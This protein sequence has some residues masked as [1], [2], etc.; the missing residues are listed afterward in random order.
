MI[1]AKTFVVLVEPLQDTSEKPFF[2][3]AAGTSKKTTGLVTQPSEVDTTG[4]SPV[5]ATGDV[6]ATLTATQVVEAPS[7]KMRV[8]TEPV[9]ANG[10]KVATQP[11]EA[12]G[13]RP[14]VQAQSTGTSS[15]KVRPVDQS[16]VSKKTSCYL[17]PIKMLLNSSRMFSNS[18]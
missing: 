6:V 10:V 1:L 12:P 14:V 4:P 18:S 2:Y 3:P 8:A 7:V 15:E 16:L 13:T 5:Q 11:V 17:T 9:E